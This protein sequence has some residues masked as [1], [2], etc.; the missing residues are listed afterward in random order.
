MAISSF[1]RKNES[2]VVSYSYQTPTWLYEQID[3]QYNIFT[4]P[5]TFPSNPLK[6]Q[7]FYT[8][9]TDGCDF[10]KWKGNVY[11]NPPYF[12]EDLEK[13]TREAAL[14]A[15]F[16]PQRVVVMLVPCKTEQFWFQNLLGRSFVK[17]YF[18]KDR[19]K[20]ENTKHCVTFS[21]MLVI[22][23]DKNFDTEGNQI[24][25]NNVFNKS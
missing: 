18:I 25:S 10:R 7:I 8:E 12:K 23:N 21:S 24:I 4:D 11:I 6:T 13:W 2:Q 20:F 1:K 14:Y 19:L 17:F 15:L 9:E 5:C 22:F 16:N 3:N